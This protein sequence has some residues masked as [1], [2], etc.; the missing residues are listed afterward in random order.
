MMTRCPANAKTNIKQVEKERKKGKKKKEEKK[1]NSFANE[2]KH[3]TY[4][5]AVH[6]Q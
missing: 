2:S 3:K 5:H 6:A 1:S 4:I